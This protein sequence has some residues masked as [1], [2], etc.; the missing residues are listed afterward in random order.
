[1][2][3]K[4]GRELLEMDVGLFYGGYICI[5]RWE[6]FVTASGYS[7]DMNHR[8]IS[9]VK[10]GDQEWSLVFY[11]IEVMLTKRFPKSPPY[12]S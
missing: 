6:L 10:V 5:C 1:M 3:L 2:Y 11:K 7:K 12:W 9:F 4:L 8:P